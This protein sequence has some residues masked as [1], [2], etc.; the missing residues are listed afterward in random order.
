MQ[1]E[2]QLVYGVIPDMVPSGVK[3]ID[4]VAKVPVDL[5]PNDPCVTIPYDDNIKTITKQEEKQNN[6]TKEIGGLYEL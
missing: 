2:N 3:P 4:K 1:V 6:V 5:A